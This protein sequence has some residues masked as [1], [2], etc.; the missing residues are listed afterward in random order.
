MNPCVV[1]D[2]T[3]IW[4][5]LHNTNFHP[6][7]HSPKGSKRPEKLTGRTKGK[8]MVKNRQ[9]SFRNKAKALGRKTILKYTLNL[10]AKV[11]GKEKTRIW[12][13]GNEKMR[14][15]KT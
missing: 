10:K 9:V 15:Q 7:L 3:R 11:E 1:K 13:K 8:R 4:R 12:G 6:T 5:R 2:N 14:Q